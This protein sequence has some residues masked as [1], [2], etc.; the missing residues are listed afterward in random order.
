MAAVMAETYSE[1]YA[2][3]GVHSGLP[4]GVAHDMMSGFGAMQSGGVAKATTGTVPLI[5]FH[6]DQDSTVAPINAANLIRG[7]VGDATPTA[8]QLVE[9]P[10]P[11]TG[12]AVRAST[13]TRY[14]GPDGAIS[15]ECWIVHGAGHAWSGGLPAGTYTDPKGPSASAEM[16]RFFLQIP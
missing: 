10:D 4:Y 14:A 6:G 12:D 16:I 7:H 15:A 1:L 3:V 8:E 13:R 11:E 2:G 9:P 5:V